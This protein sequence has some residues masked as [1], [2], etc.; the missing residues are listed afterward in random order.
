M[1][2]QSS[3]RQ[4][5]ATV[6]RASSLWPVVASP[7]PDLGRVPINSTAKVRDMATLLSRVDY[8]GRRYEKKRNKNESGA[9]GG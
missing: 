3:S 1:A 2:P 8:T 9:P 6:F 7:H 4:L 5:A